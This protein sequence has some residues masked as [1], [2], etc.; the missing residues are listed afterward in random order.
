MDGKDHMHVP[1]SVLLIKALES[2]K[3]A[4]GGAAPLNFKEG[5]QLKEQ[6]LAK[7]ERLPVV[8]GSAREANFEEAYKNFHRWK[9]RA[10][11]EK[12]GWVGGWVGE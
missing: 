11:R 8:K 2:W 6:V 7:M 4:H 3:A 10:V 12:G 9:P 1:Y 5:Q